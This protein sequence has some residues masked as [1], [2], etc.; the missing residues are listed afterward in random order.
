MFWAQLKSRQDGHLQIPKSYNLKFSAVY[1]LSVLHLWAMAAQHTNNGK[2]ENGTAA[3]HIVC[4]W[5]PLGWERQIEGQRVR[6]M[7]CN[8]L[9]LAS[10]PINPWDRQC[11]LP[12]KGVNETLAAMEWRGPHISFLNYPKKPPYN[13]RLLL[14][15]D[16]EFTVVCAF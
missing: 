7:G 2:K 8:I 10:S 11:L 15:C 9:V 6:Q 13:Q 4:G 1:L 14:T 5:I 16:T 12:M 3:H